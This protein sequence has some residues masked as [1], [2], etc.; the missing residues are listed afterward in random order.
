MKY[1]SRKRYRVINSYD[2]MKSQ[3]H[4]TV[5]MTAVLLDSNRSPIRRMLGGGVDRA[6]DSGF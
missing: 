4:L 2:R 5:S 1:K 3:L 6:T